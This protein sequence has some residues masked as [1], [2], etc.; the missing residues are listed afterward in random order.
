[1]AVAEVGPLCSD[2]LMAP[3]LAMARALDAET[4]PTPPLA[5]WLETPGA[6][7]PA[8]AVAA[9]CRMS[10][11]LSSLAF[12]ACCLRFLFSSAI[13]ALS[14]ARAFFSARVTGGGSGAREAAAVASRR[15]NKRR[16][17][18]SRAARGFSPASSAFWLSMKLAADPEA[19]AG[20]AEL[21]D[22]ALPGAL[23]L[24]G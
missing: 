7:E 22:A 17:A 14:D 23:V 2:R 8:A 24:T 20:A 3:S 15:G 16:E 18:S 5:L 11:A 21:V 12:C 4:G 6:S 19:E 9:C 10:C 1:M 13:C